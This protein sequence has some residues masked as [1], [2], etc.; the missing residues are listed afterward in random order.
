M[1]IIL[2]LDE[3]ETHILTRLAERYRRTPSQQA[4]WLILRALQS[5]ALLQPELAAPTIR[6]AL[7]AKH[8]LLRKRN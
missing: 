3:E 1:Q 7:N 8:R 5:A 6:P 2:E 4:H